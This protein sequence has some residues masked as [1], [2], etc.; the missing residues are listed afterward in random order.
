[1]MF[2]LR[3]KSVKPKAV[4]YTRLVHPESEPLLE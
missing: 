3:E 4:D 2:R 1:V